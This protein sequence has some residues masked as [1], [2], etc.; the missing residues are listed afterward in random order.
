[1]SYRN[2]ILSLCLLSTGALAGDN[3]ASVELTLLE[4]AHSEST[5]LREKQFMPRYPV[6]LAMKGIA[7]CGIFNVVVDESG[8]T[9]SIKLISSVPGKVISKPASEVIK[10]WNWTLA[11]GKSPKSEEKLLRLDFCMGGSSQE[12]AASKCKQQATMACE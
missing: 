7:G 2:T 4:P 5:W 8:S 1:M 9:E 3:Y 10:D 11:N 6:E 12:E